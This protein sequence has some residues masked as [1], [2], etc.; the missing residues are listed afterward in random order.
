MGQ[1]CE[2]Y[3]FAGDPDCRRDAVNGGRVIRYRKVLEML[4]VGR[5]VKFTVR[6]IRNPR[7]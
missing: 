4:S 3:I 5:Y 7:R 1:Q 2:I 6:T